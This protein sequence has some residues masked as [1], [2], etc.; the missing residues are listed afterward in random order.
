VTVPPAKDWL[1]HKLRHW[2]SAASPPK[3]LQNL[4]ELVSRNAGAFARSGVHRADSLRCERVLIL[5]PHPDDEVIGMGG[6]LV[7]HIENGCETFILYLTDGGGTG[8]DRKLVS[9]KRRQEA[10]SLAERFPLRQIF[11]DHPDTGLNPTTAASDLKQLLLEL[12]PETIYLPSLFEH[13]FDH[14]AANVLLHLALDGLKMQPWVAGYEVW[15]NLGAANYVVD[16]S[17][18]IDAKLEMMHLYETPM[19]YTDFA[20]L[21][22]HRNALNYLLHIHSGRRTPEGYAEAFCRLSS[23]DFSQSFV[24]WNELLRQQRNPLITH[25]D[26][27]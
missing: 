10:E 1:L 6:T 19:Q 22:R 16:I 9:T 25:L 3:S 21:I 11:W 2:I 24:T 8:S 13:H 27:L 14:Y 7:K 20:E 4:L 26:R 23:A 5:A 18:V 15:D 17:D 12:L